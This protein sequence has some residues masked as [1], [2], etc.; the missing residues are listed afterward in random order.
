LATVP[1]PAA[2]HRRAAPPWGRRVAGVR[3]PAVRDNAGTATRPPLS[4][5]AGSRRPRSETVSASKRGTSQTDR[6]K[7]RITAPAVM[8]TACHLGL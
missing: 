7:R 6:A 5:G 8:P 2:T 1:A 4:C 3:C